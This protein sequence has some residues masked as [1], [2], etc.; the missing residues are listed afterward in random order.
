LA[1]LSVGCKNKTLC[2]GKGKHGGF[3]W[4]TF[5]GAAVPANLTAYPQAYERIHPQASQVMCWV[6]GF[7]VIQSYNSVK[8]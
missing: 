1:F 7:A 4:I 8:T 6:Y 2:A 3:L 5:M